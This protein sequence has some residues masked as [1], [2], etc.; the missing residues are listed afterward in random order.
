MFDYRAFFEH[1][2]LRESDTV[3]DILNCQNITGAIQFHMEFIRN[4]FTK[5]AVDL[6][7]ISIRSINVS[8]R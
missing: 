5:A 6:T 4:I 2:F 7:L 3:T 1:L 8:K